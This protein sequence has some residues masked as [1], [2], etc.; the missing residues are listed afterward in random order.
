MER[1]PYIDEHATTV[2]S[3]RQRAWAAV[4]KTVCRNPADPSTVPPGFVLDIA[5]PPERFA[6]K[7]R[8]PFS[9][10]ALIFEL[11]EDGPGRTVVR[12]QTWAEFPGI[13]G[14]IYKALVIGSG[15]HKIVVRRMLRRIAAVA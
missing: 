7:G 11:D 9:R 6:L 8:H 4:V 3:D 14:R 15:G 13:H 1:L 2:N 5:T 12:A 10:Y